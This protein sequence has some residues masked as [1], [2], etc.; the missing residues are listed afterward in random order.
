MLYKQKLNYIPLYN[1][2]YMSIVE[3][4]DFV[5]I[6]ESTS[7]WII[8]DKT[9]ENKPTAH[10]GTTKS[11]IDIQVES[12]YI[13][14]KLVPKVFIIPKD[15]PLEIVERIAYNLNK[16]REKEWKEYQARFGPSP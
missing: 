5:R 14:N 10:I 4:L 3:E 9:L 16:K 15:I 11:L 1:H 13:N 12:C 2:S 8:I 6:E 7:D